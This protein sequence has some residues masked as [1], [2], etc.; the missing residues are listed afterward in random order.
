MEEMRFLARSRN[1]DEIWGV[2]TD[3]YSWH[4]V[5]YSKKDELSGQKDF[6]TMTEAYPC[7]VKNN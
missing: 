6:Y 3:L 4:F 5:H 7:Y 1:I 2:S